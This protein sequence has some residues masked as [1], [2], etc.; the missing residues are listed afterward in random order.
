[1]WLR[2]SGAF[3]AALA[4]LAVIVAG[5]SA[6]ESKKKET[7]APFDEDAA[8]A[9]RAPASAATLAM[10]ASPSPRSPSPAASA[11][12]DVSGA[13]ASSASRW[14][15]DCSDTSVPKAGKSIG[16]TSVVFKVELSSGKK[17]AWKPNAKKVKGRYKGEIAAYRLATELGLGNVPPACFR[18][19]DAATAAAALAKNAEA[20][21]VFADEVV[22]D[23]G[24]IHGVLIPWIDGLT[25]W[26]LEKEPL[27]SE[28]RTWL[29]SGA[30]LPKAKLALA[31][32]ASALVVFDFLT[33]NWDRYSGENV[34]LDPSG[35][36]VLYI[37]NDAGFMEQPPADR[38]A[39]NK[40]RL[41]ATDRFSRR[42]VERLRALDE[43]RLAKAFG[44]ELDGKPLLSP[45]VVS[46]V[47]ARA[48]ELL[49][50]VDAKIGAR[51]EAATLYFP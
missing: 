35:E 10:D 30:E 14:A 41:D 12:A 5:A 16:H 29:A 7:P 22:V 38:V 47:A 31:A 34:G 51:G 50:V 40:A 49:G 8:V 9:L 28:A 20:A 37:D 21:K 13:D 44:E 19:I 39:R 46:L 24:K 1:M 42:L 17:A 15:F 26:P 36:L 43:E 2:R 45:K 11:G 6:C 25:F 3:L 33:G 23:A 4:A 18:S 48:R 27:R 32:Q